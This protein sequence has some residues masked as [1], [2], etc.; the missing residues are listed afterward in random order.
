MA[1][2]VWVRSDTIWI[3]SDGGSEASS[4]GSAFLMASTVAMTSAPDWR[5]T[6]MMIA[7]S[8]FIQPARFTSYGPTMARPTSRTRTGPLTRTT[9]GL[10]LTVAELVRVL[11]DAC[12]G[13]AKV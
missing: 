11:L 2:I 6:A 4:C 3:L 8:V 7:G 13:V 1:R 10:G 12:A 5:W 9:P